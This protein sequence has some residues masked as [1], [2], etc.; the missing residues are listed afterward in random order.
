M[1]KSRQ[2]H[3]FATHSD[4]EP[5]L[6]EFESRADAKYAR[7][8]LYYGPTFEQYL[9][10]FEWDGL[11][12]NT[13]GDHISGTQFLIAKRDYR[14]TVREIQQAQLRDRVT[15]AALKNA[16]IVDDRGGISNAPAALGKFFES[17]EKKNT[18][19]GRPRED[20]GAVRYDLSQMGN[21]D[22]ITFLPGGIY[23]NQ[24]VLVCGHIGTVSASPQSLN[25]Y[26][27]FVE[28]VSGGF[29]KIAEYRVGAE[30][31]RLMDQGYRMVTIS[32]GSPGDYDLRKPEPTG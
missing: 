27:M 18:Q 13:T 22:T 21:P 7:R 12:K 19:E 3:I 23:N 4:L 11:G 15:H 6:K 1:P 28:F 32:V 24:R 29:K 10:L 30:A 26:K 17:F 14:F 31:E 9:S 5:G 2:V 20:V 8:D 25:L 16:L